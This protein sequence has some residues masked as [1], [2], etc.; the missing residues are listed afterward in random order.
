MVYLIASLLI[1]GII[2]AYTGMTFIPHAQYSVQPSAQ[3]VEVSFRQSDI[4]SDTLQEK[5]KANIE[6]PPVSGVKVKANPDYFQNSPPEYPE[7]AR[8]M[9]QEGLVMLAVDVDREGI[10]IK[11][12][13]LKSSGF[14]LLD[15]AAIN[16]G[17]DFQRRA[18][19]ARPSGSAQTLTAA[20]C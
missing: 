19:K 11:V 5:N 12:D 2:F 7:F 16:A 13:I 17:L 1:H 15:Q 20:R 8:Q 10:P 4:F 9:R 14:Q 18:M 3:M 6:S